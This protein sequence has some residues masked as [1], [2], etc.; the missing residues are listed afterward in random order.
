MHRDKSHHEKQHLLKLTE[1]ENVLQENK[2]RYK[3]KYN[4]HYDGHK[5][6]IDK[7][8][9]STIGPDLIDRRDKAVIRD[10]LYPPIDRMP[11]PLADEYLRYK[12]D[13]TF[14]V[15][16]RDSSDTYRL[17][18]YLIN[19]IDR[20]DKWNIFG[21]QRYRGSNQGDYYAI[22]QCVGH[23]PCTKI[24]LNDD[25][26]TNN[27]LRDYYNLPTTLTFTSPVFA[28]TPY[29]VVQLKTNVDFTPYF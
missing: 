20:N 17:V 18:G 4:G 10:D 21:R 16:T 19:S 5:D 11:R 22:Q 8:V 29:D 26:T 15:A 25:I 1:L 9:V 3:K 24:V 14:G 7:V 23:G 6:H 28:N 13:G 2:L 27:Q 12:L